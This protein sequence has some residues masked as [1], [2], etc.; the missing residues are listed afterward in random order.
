MD[1]LLIATKGRWSIKDVM[2]G[3]NK[4]FADL[5]KL[6]KYVK[7]GKN[8]LC[9]RKVL[10]FCNRGKKCYNQGGHAAGDKFVIPDGFASQLCTIIHPGVKWALSQAQAGIPPGSSDTSGDKR[11]R[12]ANSG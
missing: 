6:D 7:D 10:G 2:H 5:P 11:K 1:P 9:Y 12:D 8:I 4:T 3:C